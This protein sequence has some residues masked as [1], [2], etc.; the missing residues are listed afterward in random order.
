MH[1][2]WDQ[3]SNLSSQLEVQCRDTDQPTAALVKD[4]KRRGLLEDTI[5]VWGCEFGRTVFVQGDINKPN[6][7]GRYHFGACYSMWLAGG[8][9]RGGM[10]HGETDEFCYKVVRDPVHVHDLQR[11]YSGKRH[12]PHPAHVP[13]SRKGFPA[14]RRAW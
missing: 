7:H 1:S 4:L 8:G 11:P 6:G 2:G 9:F 5:V 10:V 13:I 14:D 3:H 12:R